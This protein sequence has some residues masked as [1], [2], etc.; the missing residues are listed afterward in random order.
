MLTNFSRNYKT[1]IFEGSFLSQPHLKG[2]GHK[3]NKPDE[4][5]SD[6]NDL[7]KKILSQHPTETFTTEK[8]FRNFYPTIVDDI[9]QVI[10]QPEEKIN[11]ATEKPLKTTLDLIRESVMNVLIYQKTMYL[12]VGLL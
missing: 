7:V 5:N 10:N 11:A 1:D 8:S 3:P 4:S 9:K 2:C 12:T 6:D